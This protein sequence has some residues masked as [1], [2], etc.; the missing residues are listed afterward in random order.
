MPKI[1]KLSVIS[2]L[3]QNFKFF[4]SF[5][6]LREMYFKNTGIVEFSN[7]HYINLENLTLIEPNLTVFSQNYM[8]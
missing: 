8:Y 7:G 3:L 6:Y 4:N 1:K 2:S 5:E